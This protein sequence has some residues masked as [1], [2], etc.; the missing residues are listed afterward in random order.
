[1]KKYWFNGSP[2]YTHFT[3]SWSV[4][5]PAWEEAFTKVAA[6]HRESVNNP[7]LEARIDTFIAQELSHA[8]AHNQHN[9]RAEICDLADKEFKKTK[10]IERKPGSP[11]WLATMI[12]I[13]HTAAVSARSFLNKFGHIKSREFNLYAWH[14]VEELEHKSLALDLWNHLGFSKAQLNKVSRKNFI[15][16]W[17]F[18]FSYTI[19][20]LKKDNQLWKFKTLVDG[21][22]LLSY[23]VLRLWIP[24]LQIFKQDFHP[25]HIDDT[26]L[27]AVHK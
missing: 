20:S 19:N 2:T 5:F 10:I 26:K 27:I 8:R 16:T 1:M 11:L 21:F 24:Y 13:E 9:K 14:C 6:H 15:Y 18:A 17:K 22:S 25:D 3:D 7:E 12:S 4:L 23:V